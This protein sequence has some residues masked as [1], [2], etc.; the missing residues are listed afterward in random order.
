MP[1][2]VGGD[3]ENG[4]WHVFARMDMLEQFLARHHPVDR[5]RIEHYVQIGVLLV[6]HALDGERFDTGVFDVPL[7]GDRPVEALGACRV[8][9][10]LQFRNDSAKDGICSTFTLPVGNLGR[11]RLTRREP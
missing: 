10:G 3:L 1:V 6:D 7:V 5:H 8:L 11:G 4:I 2:V 9:I